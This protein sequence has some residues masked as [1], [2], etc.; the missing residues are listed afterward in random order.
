[1][2]DKVYVNQ[3]QRLFGILEENKGMKGTCLV[4]GLWLCAKDLDETS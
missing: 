1:M 3:K 4:V 2:D